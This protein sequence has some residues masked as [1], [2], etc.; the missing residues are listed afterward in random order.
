MT[1][2]PALPMVDPPMLPQQ[3]VTL[4]GASKAMQH[5][6]DLCRRV[7]PTRA[8]VLITGETGTGK[9]LVAR[10]IHR[11][12]PRR[13]KP[14]VVFNCHG[15]P[16][17]LLESE[18][19]GHE[20]G[21]FTGAI[22]SRSGTFERAHGTTL[23]LD[24]VGDVPRAAQ[25]KLLRL[26]QER[27]VSRLGGTA[28]LEIDVR[29]IATTRYDLRSLVQH[30]RFRED[31]LYRLNVFP[32]H[33]PPLRER[34]EDIP[35][36]AT[37]FLESAARHNRSRQSGFSELATALLVSYHWPGNARQLQAVIE[38]AL[39]LGGGKTITERDL[40]AEVVGG[41]L[42]PQTGESPSSLTY[43]QRL[44]VTRAMHENAWNYGPAAK[45]LGIST[46]VLRQL[47]ATLQVRRA[48]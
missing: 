47:V 2:A 3:P 38:R 4:I 45:Q 1:L 43:A 11:H 9:E 36:L 37:H 7:A 35:R 18:L 8:T 30:G 39:L 13:D 46:H 19:F 26:L 25:A 20:R 14:L 27:R 32:I 40:P 10:Y 33:V 41:F 6:L 31:L 15:V 44:L 28:N 48:D 5:V 42:P 22:Q 17:T 16:D 29:V 24:E 23:L 12:S 21:A 34:R